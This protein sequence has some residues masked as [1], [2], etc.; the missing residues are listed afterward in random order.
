MYRPYRYGWVVAS[1]GHL[2]ACSSVSDRV[3]VWALRVVW[4]T[5]PVTAGPALSEALNGHREVR[6]VAS[7]AMWAVWAGVV[8]A[9][10][11]AHPVSLTVVRIT[12]PA[13]VAAALAAAVE[14]HASGVAASLALVA[15]SAAAVVTF[16]PNIA[17]AYVNGPA[18]PNERRYPLAPPGPLLLGPLELAWLLMAGLP[19]VAVLALADHRWIA[20]TIAAVLSVA[21]VPVLGRAMHT[22]SRRWVVFVPAGLVLCDPLNLLDPVLFPRAVVERLGPAPAGS[23]SLDLTQRAAGLA[24]ELV[25]TEKVPM[26]RVKPGRRSGE[27]GTS[28]RLLFTPTR[29]GAVLADAARRRLPVD[30]A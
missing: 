9:T 30:L 29:P 3:L 8:V 16:I 18:Y 7:V 26:V 2:R 13:A 1:H 12:A 6:S 5:L 11:V 23:D 28:A 24:L 22:L 15:T 21:A 20:G 17:V 27:A 10:L 14:G 4:A 25:L 19:S